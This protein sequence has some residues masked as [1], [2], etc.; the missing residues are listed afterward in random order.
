MYTRAYTFGGA[1]HLCHACHAQRARFRHFVSAVAPTYLLATAI[2]CG[3]VVKGVR[4]ARRLLSTGKVISLIPSLMVA[5]QLNGIL[6]FRLI[7]EICGRCSTQFYRSHEMFHRRC[8]S[9]K[10]LNKVKEF[11]CWNI[12]AFEE[13]NIKKQIFKNS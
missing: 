1:C 5:K 3:L 6:L 4:R 9:L 12:N 7:T 11:M 8:V 2:R 10:R 13:I